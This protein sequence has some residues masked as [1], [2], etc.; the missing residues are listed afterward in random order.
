[1]RPLLRR[2]VLAPVRTAIPHW[3]DDQYGTVVRQL[4]LIVLHLLALATVILA[5]LDGY[6]VDERVTYR[7]VTAHSPLGLVVDAPAWPPHY[8]TYFV[9]VDSIGITAAHWL[10][11]LAFVA[12]I[13][14]TYRLGRWYAGEDA[15]HQ[16]ALFVAASPF[17]AA[18]AGWLR[19]YGLLTAVLVWGVWWTLAGRHRRAAACWLLA[20][21]LHPFGAFGGIWAA[22]G[23]LPNRQKWS[24]RQLAT[25]TGGII[26]IVATLGYIVSQQGLAIGPTGVVH[27]IAPDLLRV[28]LTPATALAGSPHNV[29]QVGLLLAGSL[30]LVPGDHDRRLVA[31]VVLPL[32]GVTAVSYLV[33]PIYRVK[34]YG[35]VAPVVAVLVAGTPR[36]RWRRALIGACFGGAML[37]SW[38]Q[39][40][41]IPAIVARR[42][43]FWF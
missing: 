38:T 12:S 18:Q 27:G 28:V 26:P 40:L 17:L 24:R 42:F 8:P 20:A 15:G 41:H 19:M 29:I 22:A 35:F 36:A 34:Y 10:G 32:V 23:S 6:W 14:P 30:L 43:I 37:V 31:W 13:Y 5:D 3:P 2:Y 16:A 9:L 7:L 39:R 33:Q 25:A 1:M 4:S 21:S 11:R